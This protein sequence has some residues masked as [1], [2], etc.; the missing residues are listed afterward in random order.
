M[1]LTN[2]NGEEPPLVESDFFG[3]VE[4]PHSLAAGLRPGLYSVNMMYSNEQKG[5]TTGR[6]SLGFVNSAV[7]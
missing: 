6:W 7:F 1:H 5:S 3:R 4:D 2:N